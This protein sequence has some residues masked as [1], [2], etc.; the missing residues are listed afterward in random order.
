MTEPANLSTTSLHTAAISLRNLDKDERKI[1]ELAH[2]MSVSLKTS[3]AVKGVQICDL[4]TKK[5]D[6]AHDG[7]T[8]NKD[9]LADQW[10]SF[11][12]WTDSINEK[13][14]MFT[15]PINMLNTTNELAYDICILSRDEEGHFALVVVYRPDSEW[16]KESQH[17]PMFT[18]LL[19]NYWQ[20]RQSEISSRNARKRIDKQYGIVLDQLKGETRKNQA[21]EIVAT[22]LAE[23]AA[24]RDEYQL[25]QQSIHIL[26]E[27][28]GIDRAGAFVID[29]KENQYRGVYGIDPDGVYRDESQDVYKF[30]QLPLSFSTVLFD[31]EKLLHVE[32][33]ITLYYVDQPVGVGWN[34]MVV[35]RNEQEPLGWF[36]M[37]NL[38]SKQPFDVNLNE[39]F[40]IFGK[41]VARFLVEIRHNSQ[42]RMLGKALSF[43][44]QAENTH[45]LCRHAVEFAVEQLDIDRVGLFLPIDGDISQVQGTYGVDTEGNISDES[46][47]VL[48]M[49]ENEL[50]LLAQDTPNKLFVLDDMP[51]YYNNEVVGNGWNAC[52]LVR[53]ND[54]NAVCVFADNLVHKR[55][56]TSQRKQLLQ[57]FCNNVGEMVMRIRGQE[58]LIEANNSL[59]RR[60]AER[61]H[62]L[63]VVNRKLNSIAQHDMLTMLK[64]RRAYEE[65]LTKSWLQQWR[66]AGYLSL[67]V[68]DLDGFKMVNDT[69]GHQAGDELLQLLSKFLQLFCH[70]ASETVFRLGGD[71]FAVILVGVMPES[72]FSH[73][74][75]LRK[76]FSGILEE[77]YE[78]VTLSI[79]LVSVIPRD[80]KIQ[81]DFFAL[82]DEALY[83][84]KKQGK[85]CCISKDM[86]RV[87]Q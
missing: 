19:Q 49:P 33:N 81:E 13:K 87:N 35:L 68:M 86:T 38:S 84:A 28:L 61:T 85:N 58:S 15:V 6:F 79:G 30:T 67:A 56:L 66:S 42:I 72:A 51:L 10:E 52:I 22:G 47:I 34:G 65:E 16:R 39:A 57:L 55:V 53:V 18:L 60:I 8:L 37:D 23:L 77:Q 82:A 74:D 76:S 4:S 69:Y 11:F 21:M 75:K 71:E 24:C 44:S 2:N 3:L 80:K 1:N 31:E 40:N 64:N 25:L 9:T 50:N 27:K 17:I 48:A 54:V 43:M 70:R 78:T 36:A 46:H 59:E 7:E 73:L 14:G 29:V 45:D 32:D 63:E 83:Q 5:L 26:H 41:T 12:H 62:E 20:Q